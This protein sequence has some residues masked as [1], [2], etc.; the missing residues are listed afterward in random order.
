MK[1][2]YIKAQANK[3]FGAKVDALMFWARVALSLMI[4]G[5]IVAVI[6]SMRIGDQDAID[7][8]ESNFYAIIFVNFC[9][10]VY[11]LLSSVLM[12]RT[13]YLLLNCGGDKDS[14]KLLIRIW[15]VPFISIIL[16]LCF[17][18]DRLK[19]IRKV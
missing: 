18:S 4:A 19:D 12:V 2:R 7:F 10:F 17:G 5:M 13:T 8:K 14:R 16:F 9:V 3:D 15:I 11:A 1:I 6:L